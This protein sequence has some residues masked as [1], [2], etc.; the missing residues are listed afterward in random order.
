MM[1][2]IKKECECSIWFVRSLAAEY[3]YSKLDEEEC[4]TYIIKILVLK[5]Q[6]LQIL[7]LVLLL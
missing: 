7:P 6:Y 4:G 3:Y 2:K 5:N 1:S